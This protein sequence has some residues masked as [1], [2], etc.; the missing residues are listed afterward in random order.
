[1]LAAYEPSLSGQPGMSIH[2]NT[3]QTHFPI[4]VITQWFQTCRHISSDRSDMG[5]KTMRKRLPLD[6]LEPGSIQTVADTWLAPTV[7]FRTTS[8]NPF[9][10]NLL[11][12]SSLTFKFEFR[13]FCFLFCC[14]ATLLHFTF[15]RFAAHSSTET[16]KSH[17][18]PNTIA[19]WHFASKLPLRWWR[20]WR[21]CSIFAPFLHGSICLDC[22]ANFRYSPRQRLHVP[23]LSLS[24]ILYIFLMCFAFLLF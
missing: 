7:I 23:Q 15:I 22:A 10:S 2:Q 4:R 18:E 24:K 14:S 5:V 9:G 13:V 6:G 3:Q 20:F 12:G 17:H 19:I 8:P 16:R 21:L 11:P 1:M